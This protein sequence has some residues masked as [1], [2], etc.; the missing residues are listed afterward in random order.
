MKKAKHWRITVSGIVQ[1]VGFRP[2]LHR[3]AG[4]CRVTGW[5]RNTSFGVELEL[6]GN[7]SGL[8]RFRE[9]IQDQAPP[10]A[11]IDE[12]KTVR[13]PEC[14]P[15]REFRILD[16]SGGTHD[17]LISPD[18]AVCRDCLRELKDP[19]D[20]RYQY[21]FINCTSCGPR[22]TIIRDIPYDRKNTSMREFP[23]CAACKEEYENIENRRYHA[24]PDCC[25]VCGPQVYFC[26]AKGKRSKE[27][28]PFLAAQQALAEGKILAVMG[29]GGI[30]LLCN[31]RNEAAVKRLRERKEREGKPMAVMCRDIGAARKFCE[32]NPAEEKLLLS[33]AHPIVLLEKEKPDEWM[34]ISSNSRLGVM[35]PYTPIHVLLMDGSFGGPEAAVCT[36]ANVSGCPVLTDPDEAVKAL[37][38]IADVYLLHNRRIE[39]RCDDSLVMEWEERP[40]FFRRSRGYAPAP[41]SISFDGSGILALGAEQKASFAMGKGHQA[42]L[43]PHIGDLKNLETMEH[44]RK[45]METYRRLFE[46]AWDTAVCDLHPDYISTV[47][48]RSLAE[49][50]GILLLQVQH[51]WAHMASCMADNQM[52]GPAFGIIWD[53]TGLG[54]DGTVWGGE[55]L[56][57]D[58][59]S[60]SRMGAVRP[61][62]LIGGDAAVEEIG[63]LGL[64]LL[65]D[66]GLS[67]E[68]SRLPDQKKMLLEQLFCS[69]VSCVKASSVGRL[70]DGVYTLLTGR[71][72][73]SYEG[74]GAVLLE[75]MARQDTACRTY[76][77]SF[78]EEEGIR[79]LDTRPLVGDITD[80]L[81]KGYPAE[82]I[83]GG[84]MDW[85]CRGALSQCR[86]LNRERLPVA[87]SGGVFQNRWILERLSRLLKA[88]GFQVM[89]HR[90][91]AANDEGICLGQMAIAQRRRQ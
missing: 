10:L 89:I 83:A 28:D 74:E 44:Y 43:S 77:L 76:P 36:S 57:G 9:S 90:Q 24:Q 53:G 13:L 45:T 22:Y 8:E 46:T 54:T 75:A 67:A 32:I 80:D 91:T 37:R 4:K 64:A 88:D 82:E 2:F 31:V 61:A 47:Y 81:K 17:T 33:P 7:T 26:D 48:G 71:T 50:S 18:I 30:H 78:Y 27:G 56:Q 34:E 72:R 19:S 69:G 12:V 20:R 42:F 1:G 73:V 63:R 11:R 86:E 84:F 23:M 38:G 62:V 87:L 65:L 66:A 6:T 49:E 41:V 39:N 16:S 52:E 3:L 51:H 40:F 25:S 5:V 59:E 29:T 60:F 21:P 55:F 15:Y 68:F 70:F 58:F 14:L 79:W 85:L 35:L